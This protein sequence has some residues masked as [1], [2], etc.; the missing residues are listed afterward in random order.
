MVGGAAGDGTFLSG[1][2]L[3]R[4]LN[5]EGFYVFATNEY[6]SVIRGGY[7][8]YLVRAS[9]DEVYSQ[10][11]SI[12]LLI[13]LNDD[14]VIRH[15]KRLKKEGLILVDEKDIERSDLK[16]SENLLVKI[17]LS[18]FV[19]EVKGLRVMRNLAALG[20]AVALL[21]LKLDV[22][23]SV[24]RDVFRERRHVVEVNV[25]LA[26]KGYEYIKK[27]E[28]R[29]LLKNLDVHG[30][31]EERVFVT[32]NE[33]VGLGALKAGL[34]LYVAYPITPASPLLHFL[35][36]LQREYNII[37][38]QPES[39]IAAINI[40]IGAAYAGGQIYGGNIW[41]RILPDDGSS[42]LSRYE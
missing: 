17:P 42:W 18:R 16:I 31:S 15:Y 29:S 26:K 36:K 24:I 19:K 34:G 9:N 14:A 40:A 12:D 1:N 13:A 30:K 35:A 21:N 39:E 28:Q 37:V 2:I 3:A 6:L 32:G 41:S 27:K 20:A 25:T 22:L 33:A 10:L 38:L 11:S 5:R 8:W 7:Q 4:T 23:L